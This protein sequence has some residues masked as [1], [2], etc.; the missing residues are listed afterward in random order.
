MVSGGCR[1]QVMATQEAAAP[2]EVALV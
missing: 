1:A 2:D